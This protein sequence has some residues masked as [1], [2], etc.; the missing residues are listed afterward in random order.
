MSVLE[1]EKRDETMKVLASSTGFVKGELSRRIR[2][3]FLPD[4]MFKLD[5][6]IE[7]G[8]KI[9]R[10]LKELKEKGESSS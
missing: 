5:T 6:S 4:I 9:D 2:I 3:K 10:I 7:Y 1:A 8:A